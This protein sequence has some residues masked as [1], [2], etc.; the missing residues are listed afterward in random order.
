M[1][2][3]A[4]YTVTNT[5]ALRAMTQ[6]ALLTNR[7]QFDSLSLNEQVNVCGLLIDSM[8]SAKSLDV[9]IFADCVHC[10]QNDD[11]YSDL[12]LWQELGAFETYEHL[13]LQIQLTIWF[14]FVH[15]V[16]QSEKV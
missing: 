3:Q 8:N 16:T 11:E 9:L 5:G 12:G 1:K 7:N 2:V 15:G 4:L 10:V 6:P 14:S 13:R